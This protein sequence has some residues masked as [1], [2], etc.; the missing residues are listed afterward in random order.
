MKRV[1]ILFIVAFLLMLA[2]SMLRHIPDQE[3]QLAGFGMKKISKIVLTIVFCWIA[4]YQ[5]KHKK[6]HNL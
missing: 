6:T 4:F 5:Y 1:K 3:I 2:F